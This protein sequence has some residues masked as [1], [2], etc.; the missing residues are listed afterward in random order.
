MCSVL[1]AL[2]FCGLGEIMQSGSVN[3]FSYEIIV[4]NGTKHSETSTMHKFL[5][6]SLWQTINDK[7]EKFKLLGPVLALVDECNIG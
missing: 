5:E 7:I 4:V 2:H 1:L 6:I 3:N